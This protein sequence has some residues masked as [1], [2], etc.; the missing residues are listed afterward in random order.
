MEQVCSGFQWP[1][2][3]FGEAPISEQALNLKTRPERVLVFG[4]FWE[5]QDLGN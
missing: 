5:A 3:F 1:V 2:I 4:I